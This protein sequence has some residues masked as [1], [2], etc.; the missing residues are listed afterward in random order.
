[1]SRSGQIVVMVAI[2]LMVL[3]LLL[4]LLVDVGRLF[5]DR[6]R[7]ERAAQAAADAGIG[8]VADGMATL[9]IPR[10]TEGAARAACV[11]DAGYGTP[12][13]SCTATPSPQRAEA[14]LTDADRAALIAAP[15]QTRAAGEALEYAAA[16]GVARGDAGVTAVEVDYPED[17][18]PQEP[19]L[20]MRISVR[21][22][23]D[24][25]FGHLLGR[26]DVELGV[27]ALSEI[28]QR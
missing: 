17:Y 1:M 12:G 18:D 7:L 27:D 4:A 26:E 21:A 3:L 11:P 19:N 10:L 2:L 14:W 6:S 22:A 8:E 24:L 15:A 13:A 9:A 20:K 28:R 23:L 16:N 25:L 5:V